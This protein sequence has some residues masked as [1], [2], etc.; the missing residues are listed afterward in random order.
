VVRLVVTLWQLNSKTAKITSLYPGQGNLATNKRAKLQT[1]NTNFSSLLVG[2][3]GR[4]ETR[5]TEYEAD[6]LTPDHTVLLLQ[7]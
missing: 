3:D 7:L 5:F 1:V 6:A 4:T 2:L